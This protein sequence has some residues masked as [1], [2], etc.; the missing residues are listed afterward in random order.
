MTR[1]RRYRRKDGT[2]VRAHNRRKP[3]K[4]RQWSNI[5]A[6][7]VAALLLYS[8]F[9]GGEVPTSVIVEWRN[10]G[11]VPDRKIHLE[12]PPVQGDQTLVVRVQAPS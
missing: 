11:R 1:V 10:D 4:R 9:V 8:A 7:I 12:E 6:S 3:A 5:A 2:I